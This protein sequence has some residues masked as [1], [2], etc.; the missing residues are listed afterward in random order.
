MIAR[1]RRRLHF[2]VA[3]LLYYSGALALWR[4]FRQTMWRRQEVCVLG[5]HRV[6]TRSEQCRSNSLDSMVLNDLTYVKLLEYLEREFQV[7]SL[8]ALF[9]GPIEQAASSKPAC[10]LTFDDGWADNYTTAYPVLKKFGMPAVLFLATGSIGGRGGF[11]VEQL[12]RAWTRPSVRAQMNSVL[13]QAPGI[14]A[15]QPVELEDIVEWLK[16]MSTEKRNSILEQ[17]LPKGEDVGC[18]EEV[19]SMLTWIQVVEMSEHG[20]EMG[21]H[22]VSHPLLC[23]ENDATVEGELRLSKQWLEEKLGKPVRAFAYPNGNWDA[24][25]RRWVQQLGYDCAFTTRPGWY[26]PGQDPY[27][28]RRILLHDGNVTGRDGQFSPAMLSLTLAGRA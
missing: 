4:L 23:Y 17:I 2:A 24:R 13:S 3:D 21:G 14:P 16:H 9:R 1:I 27:T 25:V 26:H 12:S 18:H 15:R 20:V 22:T 11:W 28:I 5:L 6:L 19:D 7:A 10:I 8:E